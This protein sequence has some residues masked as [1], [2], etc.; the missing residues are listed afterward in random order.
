M[1]FSVVVRPLALRDIDETALYIA[2]QGNP[3]RAGR[4]HE[5][6][7][8]R[9]DELAEMPASYAICPESEGL[10]IEIRQFHYHSHESS[11]ASSAAPSR[12]CGSTTAHGGR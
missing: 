4:W 3:E 6:V 2:A 9:I 7:L 10:G 8:D 5:G 1:A 12:C 11:S